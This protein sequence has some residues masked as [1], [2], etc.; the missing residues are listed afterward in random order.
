MAE[1][2]YFCSLNDCEMSVLTRYRLGE[3][4]E[5]KRGTS[6][7][8]EYYAEEGELIRLT[9]GNFD[10]VNGGFKRNTSK[11]D[12][13]FSGIVKEEYI[14]E[15]GDIITPLTEQTYGLLGSTARIPESGKYIQSQDVALIKCNTELIDPSYCYYLI[16]TE[17][18]SK[19]LSAAAQQTKIRHTSPDRIKDVVVDI[20]NVDDQKRIGKLLDTLTAKIDI[21][22]Q[23]NRNLAA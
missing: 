9:L 4:I 17:R 21:N 10:L 3:L 16:P 2:L 8:G 19:Q 7:S 12:I 6:L 5:V 11:N 22:Q 14:L 1:F 15:K 23:I 20:P 18:V 13:Y